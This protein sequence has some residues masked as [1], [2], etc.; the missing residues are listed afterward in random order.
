MWKRVVHADDSVKIPGNE[1]QIQQVRNESLNIQPSLGGFR[2]RSFDSGWAE[3]T[4][5]N[6]VSV[7]YQVIVAS[8][9][10][11]ERLHPFGHASFYCAY[12]GKFD[13]H[14]GH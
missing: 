9:F 5:G 4:R 6:P 2:T 3:I 14:L 10:V 12:Q 7:K 8:E 13:G 1:G 11:V